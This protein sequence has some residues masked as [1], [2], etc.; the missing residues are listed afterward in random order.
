MKF[1]IIVYCLPQSDQLRVKNSLDIVN[2]PLECLAS[3]KFY[4]SF[5]CVHRLYTDWTRANPLRQ[6]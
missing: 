4:L 1:Y 2:K 5:R 3:E 6:Y